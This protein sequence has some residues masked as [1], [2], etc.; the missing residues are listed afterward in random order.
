MV[1]N[2]SNLKKNLSTDFTLVS[3][4]FWQFKTVLLEKSSP[5]SHLPTGMYKEAQTVNKGRKRNYFL[6][7]TILLES[8][9]YSPQKSCHSFCF[10]IFKQLSFFGT[11]P[12][13]ISW[14]STFCNIWDNQ[15]AYAIIQDVSNVEK[16]VF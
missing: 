8:F 1:F 12:S 3:K 5:L 7:T 14:K 9:F 15:L 10:R 4:Y 16:K 6:I 2:L 13:F 11:K